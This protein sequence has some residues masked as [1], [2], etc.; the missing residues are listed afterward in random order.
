MEKFN[1]YH[2]IAV[3]DVNGEEKW[4]RKLPTFDI[5]PIWR[6][7]WCQLKRIDVTADFIKI[8]FDSNGQ[9]YPPA[10]GYD[11][12]LVY[13][14]HF[15]PAWLCELLKSISSGAEKIPIFLCGYL[16][17]VKPD[18]IRDAL[19]NVEIIL[20]GPLEVSLTQ[21]CKQLY[22]QSE[23]RLD[24]FPK[25]G[26]ISNDLQ[27]EYQEKFLSSS[28]GIIQSSAGCPRAC[29]FCRY[30]AFYHKYY[31]GIYEQ[32]SI[33][34]ITTGIKKLVEEYKIHYI[35]LADS[36][37]L[38][39]GKLIELRT[40]EFAK[41]IKENDLSITFAIHCRSDSLT[42]V[43]VSALTCVGLKY[44]SMGI[45]SMSEGQLKRFGKQETVDDH[46]RAVGVLRKYAVHVQGY[47]ILADPLM[48]RNELLENLMGLYELNKDIVVVIHEKM[49]LYTTTNYYK[50]YEK[51]IR[52][53]RPVESSLGVVVEYDFCDAWCHKYFRFIEKT[54]IWVQQMLIKKYYNAE[55]N[56]N[57]K[58]ADSYIQKATAYRL[59]ALIAI[60]KTDDPDEEAVERIKK[61]TM[62]KID[63][64]R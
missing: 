32:Y 7:L 41:A 3:L 40:R 11:L 8:D 12:I 16:P 31:P 20:S 50:K 26:M 39:S 33:Q 4:R 17:T 46:K 15:I 35:R 9:P 29:S 14:E 60:V 42:E 58:N 43:V 1:G 61:N 28:V 6:W 59:E 54:S 24:D 5:M 51:E 47:A 23:R 48:T 52:N 19:P 64:M 27:S 45:E 37:F 13:M 53:K 2:S 18:E 10:K 34:E 49:I 56:R 62:E 25:E 38:G 55:Q 22:A 36:N 30:S 63:H 21:F 57:V 44:V